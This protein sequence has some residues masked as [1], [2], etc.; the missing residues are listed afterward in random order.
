M[1]DWD[2]DGNWDMALGFIDGPVRLFKNNGDMTFTDAGP[3]MVDGKPLTANDGGPC[4]VDW[5]GDGTLDLLLGDSD[6]N[7]RFYKGTSK[8]SLNVASNENKLVLPK[9]KDAWTPRRL[10]P[11]SPTGF[12]PARPGGRVKP[13]AADWNGDGKLD[14]LVGD[15]IDIEKPARKL[16][17]EEEKELHELKAK[18]Q[19]L[20]QKLMDTLI[21]ISQKAW[22]KVGVK[23][24]SRNTTDEQRKK[25]S[26]YYGEMMAQHK[27][28]P[29]LEIDLQNV[30]DRLASLQPGNDGT[31]LVWVYPRK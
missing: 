2:G 15:Y 23:S 19:A 9:V 26:Q 28:V 12:T 6:G 11:T 21:P 5:D 3:F 4:M 17:T 8:G 22:E 27:E 18:E 20:N 30:S 1:G 10:D 31:G 24:N 16:S 29:Q 13:F 25:W 7:V 14:L